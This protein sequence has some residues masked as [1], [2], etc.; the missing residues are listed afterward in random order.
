MDSGALRHFPWL[1]L[2]MN[3][4]R[5]AKTNPTVTSRLLAGNTNGNTNNMNPNTIGT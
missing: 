2:G 1:Y 3:N 5:S 4:M